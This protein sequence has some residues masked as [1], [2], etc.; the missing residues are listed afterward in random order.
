MQK[1][2]GIQIRFILSVVLVCLFWIGSSQAQDYP[3]SPV[4]IVIPYS[5]GGLTDI[6]WRSISDSI[7]NNIKGTIVL[8]NK[9][10]GG[11]VVGTSFV[12]NS[13]PD[14]YTLVNV[15]PEAVSIAPAFM[16]NI[17]YNSEKDLT[18]IAKASVV[19][20]AIAVR[21]ES[22]FKTLEELVSFAKANPRKLK[23]A[24][25]GIVGTPHMILGVFNRDANVEIT[26]IPFDGGGEVVTNL[27]GGHTDFA[28]ASLPSIK[29][30]VLSG[31]ARLLALCSPKR[32]PSFP[33]IPTLAEK[34]YKKSSFATALGLGGPKGLAPAIVSKW[35]ESIEK[36]LK[37]PKVIA[38]IEKIDGVV[39]D[40][41]SGEDYRKE[42]MADF[43]M[44]KE[45]VPTLPVKK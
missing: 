42:L 7:A 20:F 4:Q 31:K 29:S 36:T 15:S 5:P 6:F 30:H 34:G 13:K 24:G 8:V 2:T 28:I 41:K 12:V 40:F 33:E 14:G 39:I 18:Y 9:T 25:M 45:I 38:I 32:L 16:P 43:A 1:K 35:E 27:L 21:N 19:A 10:G 23:T 17:P 37:D 3:A 11:G 26:Y 44:F 22:P